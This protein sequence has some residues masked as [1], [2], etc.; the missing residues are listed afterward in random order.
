M[1]KPIG[2]LAAGLCG[3]GMAFL[4]P[5]CG[6]GSGSST[7]ASIQYSLE[8]ALPSGSTE[9]TGVRGVTGSSDVYLTGINQ[10]N[11]TNYA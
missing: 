9:I 8:P 1:N 6:N 11:G 7:T 5:G 10:D 2:I 4:L 3:L